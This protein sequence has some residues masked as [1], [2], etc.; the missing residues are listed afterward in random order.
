[1][2]NYKCVIIVVDLY[3]CKRVT[4]VE[5]RERKQLDRFDGVDGRWDV[6]G[7]GHS[8]RCWRRRVAVR[9]Q[10][11]WTETPHYMQVPQFSPII[12]RIIS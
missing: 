12:C 2:R 4:A 9:T 7:A 6:L 11:I 10:N 5:R 8:A 1:M 3:R